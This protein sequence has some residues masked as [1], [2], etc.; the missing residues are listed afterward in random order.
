M[1]RSMIADFAEICE[2]RCPLQRQVRVAILAA[3]K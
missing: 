3:A 1:S 2:G